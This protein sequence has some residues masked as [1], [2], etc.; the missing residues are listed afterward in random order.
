VTLIPT[1]YNADTSY[2]A[3]P[4]KRLLYL[5]RTAN[6]ELRQSSIL[7]I[8]SIGIMDAAM[9]VEATGRH[10]YADKGKYDEPR[11]ISP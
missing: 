8:P 7:N 5:D 3:G 4:I 9:V 6:P 11:L 1:V 2:L 10:K